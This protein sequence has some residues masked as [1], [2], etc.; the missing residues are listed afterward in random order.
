[1]QQKLV[2][3]AFLIENPIIIIREE[4]NPGLT[5]IVKQNV[6]IAL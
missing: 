6:K 1:M 2:K 3:N 5:W 4:I